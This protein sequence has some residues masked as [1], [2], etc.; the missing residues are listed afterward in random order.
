M[1]RTKH[2][3]VYV[4]ASTRPQ[5]V[6]M[7]ASSIRSARSAGVLEDFHVYATSPVENATVNHTIPSSLNWDN[8][9]AKTQFVADTL[10]QNEYDA[11]VWLDSDSWFVRDPGDLQELLRGNPIWVSMEGELT[12][13]KMRWPD[14]W[15]M[16]SK[17]HTPNVVDIMRAH[18]CSGEIVYST[19]GGMFV[20][21]KSAVDEFQQRITDVCRSMRTTHP[22]ISDEPPL[23]VVGQTMVQDYP[24]NTIQQTGHV[25]ACDWVGRWD[26]R[27]PDGSPWL[28][29]DW[30]TGDEWSINPAI[31]HLMR[32][33]HLMA[34]WPGH[35]YQQQAHPVATVSPVITEPVGQRLKEILAECGVT[36][37]ATCSC[38]TMRNQ[39]DL[40][41]VDGCMENQKVIVAH[42]DAASKE[43]SWLDWARVAARGYTSS[44]SLLVESMKRA[45]SLFN[46]AEL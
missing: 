11:A 41:G 4:L 44:R 40:W 33:K 35:N 32:G 45:E 16:R 3:F 25:W 43:S 17:D 20:V 42:L 46:G 29:Q 23:A 13:P 14:W 10:R 19:N 12:S 7:I 15:T 21:R 37:D 8:H 31:V 34:R 6:E 5:D 28:Y 27:L 1:N 9:M 2:D 38:N 30:M 39:M 26:Q 24:L 36:P 18:G 22:E